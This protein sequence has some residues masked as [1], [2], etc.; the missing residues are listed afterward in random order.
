MAYGYEYR[1]IAHLEQ[2]YV[3]VLL[4]RH[5]QKVFLSSYLNHTDKDTNNS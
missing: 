4:L 2:G 1:F 5:K 3:V